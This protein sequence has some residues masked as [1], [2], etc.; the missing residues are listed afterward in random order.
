MPAGR[1][2]ARMERRWAE[3]Y[4]RCMHMWAMRGRRSTGR[5]GTARERCN[6]L[7]A[8]TSRSFMR[9]IQELEPPLREAVCRR[10]GRRC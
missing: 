9:V 6:A 7:L 10:R 3:L 2:S 5:E 1:R 4:A 8:A